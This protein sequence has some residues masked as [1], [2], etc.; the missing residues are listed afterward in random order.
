M[1]DAVLN[2]DEEVG[3]WQSAVGSECLLQKELR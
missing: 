2:E 3:S 1:T